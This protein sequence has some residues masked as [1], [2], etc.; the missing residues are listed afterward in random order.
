FVRAH[1]NWD[2]ISRYDEP[3]AWVCRVAANIATSRW[4]RLQREARAM[5]RMGSQDATHA[6]LEPA[7]DEFW[8]TVRRLP[9]RQAIAL[10]LHYVD[11]RPIAEI[12]EVLNTTYAA[13]RSL[14]ERG[15][16]RLATTLKE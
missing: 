8:A 3:A 5:A 1:R 14:L 12:A 9:R 4:R 16:A 15:R 10:A 13:T 2:R 6:E 7:D 11:G